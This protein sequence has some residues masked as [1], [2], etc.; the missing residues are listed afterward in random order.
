MSQGKSLL[1][2][3]ILLL[4]AAAHATDAPRSFSLS[5]SRTFAP[6]ESVKIQLLAR[7]VPESEFRVY[8]VNDAQKFFAGLKDLHS[9][10]VQSQSPTE[11]IDQRT[12]LERLHDFKAH[13]WWLVRHFFRGQF[14]DDAR[15]NFR[16][17]QGKLGKKSRVVGAAQFAQVPILNASQ[18][19]ARWKLETPPALVSETQ[20]LP[21]DGLS[22][23]VYLIEATEGTYKAYTVALVTSIAVVERTQNGQANLYVADRKTGA[24]VEKAEVALWSDGRMQSSGTTANWT[25]ER[26]GP[27]RPRPCW[28]AA[29]SR[30]TCGFWHGTGRMRRW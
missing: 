13:L 30:R 19:V 22:A 5:T 8:R 15:D 28:T 2:V 17:Q 16:E 9:F 29:R 24:P 25:C 3:S 26:S 1:A 11:Q 23:G 21:I 4:C 20:Q 14:T 10:G 7:N 27:R 12:L 6:G 18:L